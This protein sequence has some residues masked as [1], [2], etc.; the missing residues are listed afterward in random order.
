MVCVMGE[1]HAMEGME[2]SRSCLSLPQTDT[3]SGPAECQETRES[4]SHSACCCCW[5]TGREEQ[6]AIFSPFG[7]ITG[8]KVIRSFDRQE[9]SLG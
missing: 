3:Q 6:V 9:T 5:I 8:S 1:R 4:P 2:S 7:R